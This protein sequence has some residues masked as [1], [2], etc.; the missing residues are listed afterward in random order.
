MK[1]I[2]IILC[3][4]LLTVVS[5]SQKVYQTKSAK[6]SFFSSTPLQNIEATNNEGS[7][8]LSTNGQ[9]VMMIAIRSFVFE[10]SLMQEHFNENYMESDKFPKAIFMG[11][12][13]NLADINFSKDGTYTANVEGSLEIHGVKNNIKTQVEIN[14]KQNKITAKTSFSINVKDYGIKGNYIGSKIAKTIKIA[15]NAIYE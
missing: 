10:N 12:I 6:I 5:F 11:N 13:T 4:C 14:I 1:K 7:S 8:K 9:V 15:V 2:F 3:C